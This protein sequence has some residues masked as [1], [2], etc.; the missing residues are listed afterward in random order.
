MAHRETKPR[1]PRCAQDTTTAASEQGT[2]DSNSGDMG[3]LREIGVVS[4]TFQAWC[5]ARLLRQ[6][7]CR[8]PGE[9]DAHLVRELPLAE[10]THC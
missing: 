9:K 7:R 6:R 4:L 8:Q 5:L 10:T 2:Q 3:E 1:R